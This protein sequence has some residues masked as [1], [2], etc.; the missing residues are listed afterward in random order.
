VQ[1]T[2]AN[3][4]TYA[5]QP[6]GSIVWFA[7]W[8]VI[9]TGH[10]FFKPFDPFPYTLLTTIVSLEAIFL[11]L[12]VLA[13]ENRLT[14]EADRRGQLDLQVNLLAEQEMTM[15]LRMLKEICDHL[16]LHNSISSEDFKELGVGLV[17]DR[18]R[19]PGAIAAL[20]PA[21]TAESGPSAP[22]SVA[23][24]ESERDN[25]VLPPGG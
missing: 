19:L 1:V 22:K 12:F 3:Q 6:L 2:A 17:G 11:T 8:I 13:S 5:T 25:T 23:G 24:Q 20:A 9:N 21:S 14:Q 18:R 10:T 7:L 15:V 4:A 16:K